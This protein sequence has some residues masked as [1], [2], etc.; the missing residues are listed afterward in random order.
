MDFFTSGNLIENNSTYYLHAHFVL[1]SAGGA[2]NVIGY[3][4]T[5]RSEQDGNPYWFIFHM[6]SHGGH[7]Y[8]NLYEGNVTGKMGA[9]SYWGSGSHAMY[10]RNRILRQNIGTTIP[11]NQE[12]TAINIEALNY[13]YT[14]LGNIVGTFGC[15]GV[16]EQIP[17]GS[18]SGDHINNPVLWKIGFMGTA[19]VG[20][21]TDPKVAQTLLKAGNWECATNAVQWDPNISDHNIPDSL[22]L[23]ST[24][25]WF[26]I[27]PWPP[28]TP[29]RQGFNP[30][31]PNKIPAQV[32]FENGPK[33]GLPYFTVQGF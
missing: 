2:G 31:N 17:Y 20:Y 28:F 5:E 30:S 4:Y 16:V 14:F 32:R 29:E 27:L 6:G 1:G 15:D 26:G 9:D 19:E 7:T 13:Y 23:T 10:F 11:N 22:Y 12:M 3:N 8:M 21:P 33:I 25:A 24:P 18:P